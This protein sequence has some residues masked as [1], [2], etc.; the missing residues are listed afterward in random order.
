ISGFAAIDPTTL[1]IVV[2]T[3]HELPVIGLAGRDIVCLEAQLKPLPAIRMIHA[4]YIPRCIVTRICSI[5][6]H[7]DT[8][9]ARI[10]SRIHWHLDPGIQ[11]VE[12]GRI[13][14]YR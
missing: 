11:P 10:Q 4:Y 5:D 2:Y 3:K 1:I 9:V 8:V 6:P 12:D 13:I 14:L 7:R